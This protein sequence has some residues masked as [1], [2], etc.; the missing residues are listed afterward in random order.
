VICTSAT[1]CGAAGPTAFA[2]R[3]HPYV[4]TV[5][6]ELVWRFNLDAPVAV[7]F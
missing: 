5:R 6:S 1:L 3:T 2:E 7:R 4:Q